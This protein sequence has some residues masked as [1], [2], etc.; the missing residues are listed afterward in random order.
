MSKNCGHTGNCNCATHPPTEI[1]KLAKVD[2]NKALDKFEDVK[3]NFK[4]E[5]SKHEEDRR[6]KPMVH[7]HLHTYHS[8]LDG[9]GSIDNYVKLAREYNHPA[10][11]IT[12]HGTLSGTFEMYKKCKAAGIKSIMGMEAYVNDNQ[13]LFEEKKYEGGNSH[14]SIFVMNKEGFVNMNKLAYRSYDEGFYKRGRIKTEWLFEHKNG[15]FITTS[16]AGSR[17][18]RLVLEGKD[19]DAEE[20]LKGLMRE[21]GDNV[22]AEL[23][24]NEFDGQKVYNTWLLKMIKKYSL[25]P[26]LT[27][28]VHYAFKDD[29]ILQ[30]TLIAINQKSML[31]HAFKLNTRNLY[32]ASVDDFHDFN[33]KFGFNYPEKFVDLCLENTL[34]VSEKL[35]FEFD[36]K[37]EK[38]PKYEATQDVIDYFKT[39]STKEI[40][41]KLAFGKLRQK[42]KKYKENNVVDMT[43]EKE[44]EYHDRLTYELQ[45]IEEKKTL[46]YF[47]VYWEM[48]RDY[49]QKGYN[50]GPARGSAGGC[51]LSWCLEITDVDPIRF[52]LYFER[53]LNPTRKGLPDIDVDFMT[54]TDDVTNEFL[55][56]KY[57][58]NRV[59]NVS[60]FS[61]FSEKGCLKDVVRAHFGEEET[62]FSSD[63]H[64]VTQEMPNWLKVEYS[65]KDWFEKWPK[66]PACSE[67]V[68]T[69]LTN[70]DNEKILYQ[71]LQLQGQIRGIGQHAAGIVI[72]PGPC[73]EYIPTNIIGSNKSIVTAFQEADKSGK[74]LSELNILKL[75]RLKLETLNV[76]KDAIKII[77]QTRGIDITEDI[78]VDSINL[79]DPNLYLELRVGM[80]H[81]IF[82]FESV[83]M[84]ALIRGMGT[85]S[86]DELVAANAL[87]RPGPMGIGAHEEYIKNKFNPQGISYVHP[88]LETTLSDT[89]GVLIYQ[90]QLMF[91]ANKIGGMS[92]GEGDQLRR[93]MDKA[94]SAIAKK[95]SGDEMTSKD[96][97]NYAEFEKYWN[98][99]LDGASKQGYKVE[100]IDIVK[101]WVIKYLGYSFN[102]SHATAYALLAAQ[103]LYLK[104]Y[105]PTEFYTALLNHP[106]TSGGKEKEQ[107]WLAAAIASAMSKGIK[108]APP[109]RKS[110]WKWTTTADME[111]SMGFSGINGLGDTAYAELNDLLAKKDR[112]LQ[113]I[114][115]S[116]FYDLPFSKFNKKAFESCVKAG[117][118]DE[119]SESREYLLTL[120][121]KKKKKAIDV[122]QL[123]MFDMGSKEFDIKTDDIGQCAKTTESQKRFDF[124]EVCNFD[125]EKIQFMLK[126]KTEINNKAT[127]PIDNIINFEEDGWYFFVLEDFK[128]ML[129]QKGKEYLTMRVGDGISHTNLRAFSPFSKKIIPI[130]VPNGIYVARFEKNDGGF[131]NFA[132]STQFKKFEI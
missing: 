31:G 110:G 107:S 22:V 87:Y 79:A 27:N 76:I 88:A 114:S 67:R 80:N 51:L 1:D 39:D 93:Y 15:L 4:E 96:E 34:K 54:G 14:Q 5:I 70:P 10:I 103:T 63:V 57:G 37:T 64:A 62:G 111:I 66:D 11:A 73:W 89:N 82:Q 18:S 77:K 32:Y 78:K 59:L 112:T 52:G 43:P 124:I 2:I 84:N 106:K 29:A 119:W 99:F 56:K 132:K 118:F 38:Y 94:S 125:L 128:T 104:H 113:T 65:L 81:G 53:F 35:N 126:V 7:L 116:E 21:F 71:T 60:T 17:M 68:K 92:L 25:M 47:L 105:Y 48:I 50:I 42:I 33:A 130:L 12:D 9:C 69:W 8:I 23:Q 90:E 129:S 97:A 98:K 121:E 28:D 95:S 83:G 109:S 20:Y 86:F 26:I 100:E 72:T 36:M 55:H 46:D 131:V 115:V 75:D 16:C 74:D 120:K 6:K 58:K 19:A 61:T 117:V 85:E 3:Q 24:F 45:V 123:S 91:L 40:I 101:D 108:I 49:K 13:G 41:T 30:D 127:R 102:K 44:K 122:N